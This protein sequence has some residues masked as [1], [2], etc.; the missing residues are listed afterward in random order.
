MLARGLLALQRG[1][2]RTRKMKTYIPKHY[3]AVPHY[4]KPIFIDVHDSY[5]LR[6]KKE[7]QK[8][9]NG[10]EYRYELDVTLDPN[11]LDNDIRDR[12]VVMRFDITPF[13]FTK[14]QR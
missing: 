10:I 4:Y 13:N 6:S 14:L 1:Y 11:M 7:L 5:Q 9:L 3:E 2:H 12:K 8:E